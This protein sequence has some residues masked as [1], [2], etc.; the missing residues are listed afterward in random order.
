MTK[1]LRYLTFNGFQDSPTD[2]DVADATACRQW[3]PNVWNGVEMY[4]RYALPVPCPDL[5]KLI[6]YASFSGVIPPTEPVL[7]IAYCWV[8]VSRNLLAVTGVRSQQRFLLETLHK[9]VTSSAPSFGYSVTR[10]E[11]AFKQV[12]DEDFANELFVGPARW[13]PNR[14]ISAQVFFRFDNKPFTYVVFRDRFGAETSQLLFAHSHPNSLGKLEW[15]SNHQV[16]IWQANKRDYWLC[17]LS[18]DFQFFYPPADAGDPH[19]LYRLAEVLLDGR[20]VIPDE[21]TGLSLL[22]RS[23]AAGYKH[24]IGRLRR[25]TDAHPTDRE[26]R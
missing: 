6:V 13:S 10:F 26:T 12:V 24:A 20:G 1:Y 16:R 25:M 8:Q 11:D 21:E 3:E 18:G 7:G 22:E 4:K 2:A 9:A 15:L 17:D 19:S 23:A 14:K 5:A